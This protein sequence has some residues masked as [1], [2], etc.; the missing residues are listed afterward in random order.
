MPNAM[1]G[2]GLPVVSRPLCP[3]PKG[4]AGR[5]E[6]A[7]VPMKL[8]VQ[9]PCLNE[10]ETLPGTV[11]DIPRQIEGVDEVELLIIDDGSA[12]RTVEVAKELGVEHV[13]R[14]TNNKGLA[15]AFMAGLDACLKAG[16]DIIVNTDGD[17]QY[18][19]GCIPDL[20][21]PI[22]DGQADM[23]VGVRPI[24]DIADFSCLK[25]KLQKLGSWVVR[26]LSNT[27][28]SDTT[29]GF[30]AYNRDAALKLNVISP[31]SYTLETLIQAGSKNIAVAQVPI[32]TNRKTRESRLFKGMWSYIKISTSTMLRMYTMFRPLKVFAIL[33]TLVSALGFAVSLRWLYLQYVL[34]SGGGHVQSLIL[35][36]IL[37]LVGFQLWTVAMVADVISGNRRLVEDALFRI[38]RMEMTRGGDEAHVAQAEEP[39]KD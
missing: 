28:I 31:F 23:V 5:A 39:K 19:G 20:I 14:F 22:V 27:S 10:E 3:R 11:R 34:K 7:G 6:E 17:N 16:A 35:A 12:D 4:R 30:R 37:L 18:Q 24:D 15:R 36:A 26:R 32:Q 21:R 38:R 2:P 1:L 8:I 9:I 25:K 33:G 29:S 13:V